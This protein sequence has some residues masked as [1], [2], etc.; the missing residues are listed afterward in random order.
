MLGE[1]KLRCWVELCGEVSVSQGRWRVG[2][3][4]TWVGTDHC[5]DWTCAVTTWDHKC[6]CPGWLGGSKSDRSK[7]DTRL[8]WTQ[9]CRP[10]PQANTMDV[11]EDQHTVARPGV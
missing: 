1:E 7:S 5:S 4:A 10:H 9:E 2:L 11:Q 8:Y 3:R 6:W